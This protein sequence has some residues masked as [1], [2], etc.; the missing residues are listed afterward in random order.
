MTRKG[1]HECTYNTMNDHTKDECRC[2]I[3]PSSR[4]KRQVGTDHAFAWLI[5]ISLFQTIV[6][7]TIADPSMMV[8]AMTT[9]AVAKV[10]IQSLTRFAVKGLSGDDLP[11]SV[12]I[13]EAGETFP[14]DR[15]YALIKR[16]KNEK[17]DG[18]EKKLLFDPTNPA[19]SHKENFLCAFTAPALMSTFDT[20]CI[21]VD[22]DHKYKDGSGSS[23]G[24]GTRTLLSVWKRLHGTSQDTGHNSRSHPPLID[25]VDLSTEQGRAQ[26][27]EFFSQAC[28]EPVDMVTAAAQ[29]SSKPKTLDTHTHTHQFG[30]TSSGWK[31]RGDTRTVHIINAA[32]VRQLSDVLQENEKDI[33]P[34]MFP[35]RPSRFRPNVVVD[36]LEPWEEFEWVGKTLQ[37]IAPCNT[38]ANASDI[39]KSVISASSNDEEGGPHL[40]MQVLSRTV[41]CDG[42]G[43]DPLDD[44]AQS[45]QLDMPKLINKYFPEHGPYL[46]VYAVISHPG[47]ISVGDHLQLKLAE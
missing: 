40:H 14:N 11:S 29:P 4:G 36:G 30:N 33:P 20:Q 39:V 27:S 1:G 31:Q 16:R 46:G 45:H 24:T 38:S 37:V 12:T 26:V 8:H 42:I 9:T 21:D 19:W 17:K 6:M 23:G 10:E 2:V 18:A 5:I 35:L 25:S 32:T 13:S 44:P 3:T 43:I 47:I 41:R 15:R 28:G 34:A 22:V 7:I